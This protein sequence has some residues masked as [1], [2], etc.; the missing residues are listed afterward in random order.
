[1]NLFCQ[2]VD[3][4]AAPAAVRKKLVLDP[5]RQKLFLQSCRQIPQI[6]DAL[7]L[8]TCNRLEFYFCI[9]EDFDIS[10]FI[11]AFISYN[12]WSEYK[13]TFQNL[14]V[15]EH[16]F[17]LAAGVESQIIGEN[18]IFAQLKSAYSFALCCGTIG[19]VFHRLLHSAFRLAKAVR[20]HTDISTGSLSVAQAA[21]ELAAAN[22]NIAE[23]KV[24]IIGSG[25]NAELILR[26]L[27]RKN[28]EDITIV[29]R[30]K[31]TAERLI[32]KNQA[33]RFLPL[34]ELKNHLPCADI[35]FTA[36]SSQEPLISAADL[37]NCH[38]YLISID[39]SVP[40][41]VEPQAENIKNIKLFNID[42]L[43]GIININNRR[44]RGQIP[45]AKILIAEHLQTFVRWLENLKVPVR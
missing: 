8:N 42:S 26:H 41:N 14:D 37:E 1:M 31:D 7:L 5:A 45:K 16:L 38:N 2:S 20:T 25:A 10:A 6:S 23:A 43:N 9:V 35:V 12:G 32:E 40:P 27:I 44:R 39:L 4:R 29:A 19:S 36:S 30:N 3:F 13:R 33:G 34:A 18:E 17:S 24:L 22:F 28:A 21:V 11:D 15:A